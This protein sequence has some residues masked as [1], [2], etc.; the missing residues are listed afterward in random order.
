MRSSHLRSLENNIDVNN[1]LNEKT[2]K[3]KYSNNIY[4]DAL[5]AYLGTSLPTQTNAT[6]FTVRMRDTH[7]QLLAHNTKWTMIW[8]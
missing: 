2:Q 8:S 3:F 5:P 7:N 4:P 6:A 1:L